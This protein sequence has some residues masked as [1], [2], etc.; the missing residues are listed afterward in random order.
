MSDKADRS[1]DKAFGDKPKE[2]RLCL[3]CGEE[4]EKVCENVNCSFRNA[5]ERGFCSKRCE[6]TNSE[7]KVLQSWKI[8][9]KI[10]FETLVT[11]NLSE[12]DC[13]DH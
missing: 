7:Y 1:I 13:K 11:V 3:Y 6:E 8:H 2:K 9:F 10:F 12:S 4:Y 5:G